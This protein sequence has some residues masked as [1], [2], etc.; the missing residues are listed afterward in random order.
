MDS[1]DK[2]FFSFILAKFFVDIKCEKKLISVD[3]QI[4]IFVINFFVNKFWTTNT[5]LYKISTSFVDNL[6]IIKHY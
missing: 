4:V 3:N 2:S 5:V 1:G 6:A